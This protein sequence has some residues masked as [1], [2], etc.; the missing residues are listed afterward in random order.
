MVRGRGVLV[1]EQ[2]EKREQRECEDGRVWCAVRTSAVL[3][4]DVFLAFL[5]SCLVLSCLR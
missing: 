2:S 4:A 3:R 5:V 1:G